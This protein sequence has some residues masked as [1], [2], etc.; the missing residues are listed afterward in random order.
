MARLTCDD[1]S[2]LPE[3]ILSRTQWM[4]G[5]IIAEV[6]GTTTLTATATS[7]VVT[8]HKKISNC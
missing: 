3:R 4:L 5:L 2:E 6:L 8:L 7:A 1:A